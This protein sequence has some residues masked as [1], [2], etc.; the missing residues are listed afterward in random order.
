MA[1]IPPMIPAA[2]EGVEL[3]EVEKDSGEDVSV[4]AVDVA[5]VGIC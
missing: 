2:M 1:E 5:E 4:T 3:C